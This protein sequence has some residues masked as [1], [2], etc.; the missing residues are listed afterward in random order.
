METEPETA[1]LTAFVDRRQ[2][3]IAL[4]NAVVKN[5]AVAEE[6]VQESWLQW[7]NKTYPSSHAVPIFKRIVLNLAKDWHRKQKREWARFETYAL[8]YDNAP[9]TE[10]VVIARQDLLNVLRALNT[11]PARSLH[12]FRLSRVDGLTYQEIAAKLGVATSTAYG[13]V[14]DALVQVTLATGK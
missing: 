12:A 8:L 14:A 9:D 10:H 2:D 11:L 13:I 3:L 4:A 7:S 5:Q 1:G 6:L